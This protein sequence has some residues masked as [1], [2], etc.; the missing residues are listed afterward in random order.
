MPGA[1]RKV[2]GLGL[3][4]ADKA[5]HDAPDGTKQADERRNRA[6]GRQITVAAP[7]MTTDG[8]NATLKAETG[9]FFDAFVIFGAGGEFQFVLRFIDKLG[10]QAFRLK[11]AGDIAGLI[12]SGL[13]PAAAVRA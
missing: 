1:H 7:H 13:P 2:G 12:E 10:G 5:V 11:G 6:D 3:G 8:R 9:T 4:N